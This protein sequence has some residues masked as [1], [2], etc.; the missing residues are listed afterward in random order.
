MGS[1]G[2]ED[3]RRSCSSNITEWMVESMKHISRDRPGWRRSVR[4]AAQAGDHH[5]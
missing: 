3:I 1:E 2:L 4:C 5:S